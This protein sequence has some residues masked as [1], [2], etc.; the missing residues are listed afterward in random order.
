MTLAAEQKEIYDE[1]TD[2]LSENADLD[3]S[4][5]KVNQ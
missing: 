4:K 1:A 2:F 5:L 3:G